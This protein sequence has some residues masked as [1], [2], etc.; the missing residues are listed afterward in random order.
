MVATNQYRG[1]C[2]VVNRY[3]CDNVYGCTNASNHVC[4]FVVIPVVMY[5]NVLVLSV[6]YG[7]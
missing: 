5:V 7:S 3:D 4:R 2:G 1:Y 6:G